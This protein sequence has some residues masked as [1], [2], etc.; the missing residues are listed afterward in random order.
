V[1]LPPPPADG[2]HYFNAKSITNPARIAV[3]PDGRRAYVALNAA[4][5]LGV[6]DLNGISGKAHCPDSGR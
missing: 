6:I 2:R 4:N 1:D 3:S 5:T